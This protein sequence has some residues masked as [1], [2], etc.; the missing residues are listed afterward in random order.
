MKKNQKEQL[1]HDLEIIFHQSMASGKLSIALK[2]KEL[3]GKLNGVISPLAKD[4]IKPLSQW[5]DEEIES[6]IRQVEDTLG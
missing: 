5:S 1:I 2:T 6:F 3:L 4:G